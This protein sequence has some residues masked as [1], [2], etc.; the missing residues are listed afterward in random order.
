[1][2][3]S[4]NLFQSCLQFAIAI[5]KVDF[6]MRS[7]LIGTSFTNAM[8]PWYAAAVSWSI[9][10]SLV[11]IISS[12]PMAVLQAYAFHCECV[13]GGSVSQKDKQTWSPGKLRRWSLRTC[14]MQLS[15][16]WDNCHNI[17]PGS[18]LTVHGTTLSS[19]KFCFLL[20][21]KFV[22]AFVLSFSSSYRSTNN[23]L[24][25]WRLSKTIRHAQIVCGDCPRI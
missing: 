7:Y 1:M 16:L 20:G 17:L 5:P 18:E 8:R 15:C 25:R 24:C 2:S 21:W 12:R 19:V 3:A 23:C 9:L 4:S 6:S 10:M 22:I 13:S 14:Q 11:F